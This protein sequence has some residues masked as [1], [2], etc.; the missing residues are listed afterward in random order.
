MY[1]YICAAIF[2]CNRDLAQTITLA[3]Y[4]CKGFF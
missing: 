4:R 1:V 3:E 2:V